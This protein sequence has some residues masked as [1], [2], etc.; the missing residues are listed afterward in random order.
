[1]PKLDPILKEY[2][3]FFLESSPT[4]ATF[5]G[6]HQYDDK[7]PD[8]SE[9]AH[10]NEL[11]RARDI[12]ERLQQ[13]TPKNEFEQVNQQ[14]LALILQQK[15]ELG[16][17]YAHLLPISPQLGFHI[18]IPQII[19]VHP[20]K[21]EKDIQN[22]FSRL[23]AFPKLVQQAI[24][25][26]EKGISLKVVLPQILTQRCIPQVKMFLVDS[27]E[28]SIFFQPLTS[29]KKFSSEQVLQF[30][31]EGKKL[32]HSC[33]L[34]GY[35]K[36]LDFLEKKYLPA[37]KEE[38]GLWSLPK[39]REEYEFWIRY[40]TTT[41]LTAEEIHEIGLKELK[42]VHQEMKQIQKKLGFKG[43]L[44][45]FMQ[46]LRSNPD[47][48]YKSEDDLMEGFA[49]ILKVMDTKMPELFSRLP[50]TPYGLKKIEEYRAHSAPMAYYYPPPIK[51]SRKGYFYVN[52][53]Q[54]N[55]RPKY[56][57]EV[58]A[59]HEAVPGHHLQI[60]LA[61]EMKLPEFR[62]IATFTGY[63]EGWGLYSEV[64]PKEVGLY[65]DPYSEFGRLIFDAWRSARLVVD[66]GIHAFQWS[67][68]KAIQFF[69]E[70]T[71]LT[72]NE[73]EAEVDRYIGYPGQALAYKIG[74]RKILELRKKAEK[75]LGKKFD[76][77]EFHHKMLEN[78]ALPL[79]VLEKFFEEWL[80]T[81]TA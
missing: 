64:L 4:T 56:Q 79:V 34:A 42:R 55:T 47:F 28:K 50:K 1:M 43:N 78:G 9:A 19:D 70:E 8:Y 7:L 69:L 35:Q 80:T 14:I 27:A 52:T 81:K 36:L 32:I 77:K 3:D 65:S 30:Q 40:H 20:F 66:T 58:L 38:V 15:L 25:L 21:T 22:Y 2:W 51:G 31:K 49:A 18:G 61:K 75:K 60:A 67:R 16:N 41:D 13:V 45:E 10:E 37:S 62:R 33:I 59:Y 24:E 57:M 68:E 73:V 26:M 5:L 76:L 63:V 12:L 6:Y 53:S 39:G 72:E 74:Q 54:L 17:F 29:L 23:K 46:S 11:I 44:I 71:G 48:Y